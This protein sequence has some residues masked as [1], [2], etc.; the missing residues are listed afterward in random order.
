L[1]IQVAEKMGRTMRG[2]YDDRVIYRDSP[3]IVAALRAKAEAER[4]TVSE[5]LRRAARRE[6]A[7]VQ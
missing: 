7:T 4:L 6:L 1:G 2:L 5:V 3:H